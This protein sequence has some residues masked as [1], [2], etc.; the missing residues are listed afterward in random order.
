MSV[1]D[2]TKLPTELQIN[3]WT[4]DGRA[5]VTSAL[6]EDSV[7]WALER[8]G[9]PLPKLLAPDV[10]ADPR[11]WRDPAVGWGLVLPDVDGLSDT[12]KARGQDAPEPIR[13]LLAARPGS[14]V[15]RY[16]HG[17]RFTQIRRYYEDRP[18]QD[19]SLSASARGV[20]P[21]ELPR[22]LLI[23]GHPGAIPWQFQ[24]LLNQA[25]AVGR[26]TLTGEPLERYV[27][28]LIGEWA[29]TRTQV[30]HAVVWAVDHGPQDITALM[31]RLIA[32]PVQRE[33]AADNEIGANAIYLDGARGEATA[34]A[35]CGALAE[36]RPGLVVTTSH[37]KTGPLA[38]PAAMLR[39]LGL[40][41]DEGFG[42]V[43]P[44]AVLNAWEPDGA[45]WY[46]HACCS[47]GNDEV[48]IF[49]G[50]L[51]P[52]SPV[53]RLLEGIAAVGAHV[54]PFPEALLG[55][56]K[57]L[58]AFVGHVEP[59]F[60]WT[61]RHKQTGQPLTTS[62]RQALYNRLFQPDPIGYALREPYSHV[63]ELYVE[64]DAAHRAFDS[65]ENTEA[66]AMAA[67]LGARD[68]QSMVILGDPTVALPPLPSRVRAD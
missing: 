48:T 25:C 31:R 52:G 28:A 47:A 58:R 16:R 12:E 17:L 32:A 30:T 1:P 14:P 7:R 64:R 60:D 39:D 33:L 20:G 42:L 43:T 35:L 44:D 54:A 26:L 6:G 41:V 68:R 27:G 34:P 63:G 23:Y 24:Y 29:G 38:D 36:H 37:G 61:I 11:N 13:A 40:L 18:A 45:I 59:T 53:D 21:G 4:G 19:L 8:Y 46:A 10:P 56:P 55:A 49:R 15:L 57:P 5:G 62:I 66:V 65:G 2:S 67:Q 51:E 50:L 3:A 9:E 22:Y